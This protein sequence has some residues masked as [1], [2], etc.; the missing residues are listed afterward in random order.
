[1]RFTRWII[2]VFKDCTTG[3]SGH[4]SYERIGAVIYATW[5]IAMVTSVTIM[6][7]LETVPTHTIDLFKIGE[8]LKDAGIA[9]GIGTAAFGGAIAARR[10]VTK[11]GV[12]QDD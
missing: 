4:Y 5:I 9:I 10:M 7:V 1:M 3:R 12:A 11:P 8:F 2:K 6:Y